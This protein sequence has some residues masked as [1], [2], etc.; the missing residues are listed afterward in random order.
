[1]YITEFESAC[2]K[3]RG[4]SKHTPLM[5]LLL[6][7]S[8]YTIL[9]S[10]CLVWQCIPHPFVSHPT[11]FTRLQNTYTSH[12]YLL[13]QLLIPQYVH[14]HV[15]N[16]S[17]VKRVHY[18]ISTLFSDCYSLI[19]VLSLTTQERCGLQRF[20][21]CYFRNYGTLRGIAKTESDN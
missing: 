12:S 13:P 11:P 17:I 5:P 20:N 19:T 9:Q 8:E 16:Y 21:D 15:R 10:V 1:M 14:L 4:I 18:S 7:L 3:M 2:R 6:R